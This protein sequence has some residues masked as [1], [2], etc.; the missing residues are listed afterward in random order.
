M[1]DRQARADRTTKGLVDEELKGKLLRRHRMA[2][3][4]PSSTFIRPGK[5]EEEAVSPASADMDDSRRR[6]VRGRRSIGQP[7][8]QDASG[9][10]DDEE[11][12]KTP[13]PERRGRQQPVPGLKVPGGGMKAASAAADAAAG[14]VPAP[15]PHFQMGTPLGTPVG[16]PRADEASRRS[17]PKAANSAGAAPAMPAPAAVRGATCPAPR[18]RD[19]VEQKASVEED[20]EKLEYEWQFEILNSLP[21]KTAIALVDYLRRTEQERSK[22]CEQVSHLQ[23]S[24]TELERRLQAST[25]ELERRSNQSCARRLRRCCG[26]CFLLALLPVLVFAAAVLAA[27]NG[28]ELPIEV[29]PVENILPMVYESAGDLSQRGFSA[30]QDSAGIDLREFICPQGIRQTTVRE[31]T[32]RETTTREYSKEEMDKLLADSAQLERLQYDIDDAVH[33]G[34]DMV[35]WPL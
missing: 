32:I 17:T 26:F 19:Q 2:E 24:N 4:D 31:M 8:A 29:P 9:D 25:K 6:P 30:F 16:T 3:G 33:R 10:D 7:T 15:S 21:Q 5:E 1:E 34:Q 13:R 28:V 20:R 22:A 11:E 35:C 18:V 23:R 14:T 12:E 27:K